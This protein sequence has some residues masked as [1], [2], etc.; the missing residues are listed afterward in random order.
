MRKEGAHCHQRQKDEANNMRKGLALLSMLAL[1]LCGTEQMQAGGGT[2]WNNGYFWTL[3]YDTGSASISFPNASQYPGNYAI[4]WNNCNNVVGGKGWN[5]GSTRTIGYNIGS[6]SGTWKMWGIYGWTRNPLIEY[7]VAE[8][9]S[10]RSGTFVRSY[11]SDGRTYDF[12]KS[13]RVNAPSIIGTATFWQY[14]ST[15]GGYSSGNRSV[16]M[17]NHIN[18]WRTYGGQGFGSYDYQVG[19]VENWSGGSGSVN[20]TVW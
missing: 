8:K 11:S 12:Y 15:W 4:T 16:T 14:K 1:L 17:A 6:L 2:G 9:G 13:Q 7:Y 20:A 5:P 18:Q 19:A 3:W 10:M